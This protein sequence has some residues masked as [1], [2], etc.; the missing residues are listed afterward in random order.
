MI[1]SETI[2]IVHSN[3]IDTGVF[4][5]EDQDYR[6]LTD[7]ELRLLEDGGARNLEDNEENKRL[8]E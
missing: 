3:L 7:E 8:L 4:S 1:F 6:T 2:E 5:E